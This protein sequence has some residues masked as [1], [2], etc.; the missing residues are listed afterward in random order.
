MNNDVHCVMEQIHIGELIKLRIKQ[1]GMTKAEFSRRINKS[2]QNVHDLLKRKSVDTDL[3]VSISKVLDY[4][5]FTA[6]I[7]G[8]TVHEDLNSKQFSRKI[9]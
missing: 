3:L 2:P 5:F 8:N 7:S 4:N 1:L 6:Y 9:Q